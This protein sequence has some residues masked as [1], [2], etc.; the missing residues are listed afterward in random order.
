M[1]ISSSRALK[2]YIGA[3]NSDAKTK[4]AAIKY[5]ILIVPRKGMSQ[6]PAAKVPAMLPMVEMA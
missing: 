6:K 5:K 4:V 1:K 3:A 2:N